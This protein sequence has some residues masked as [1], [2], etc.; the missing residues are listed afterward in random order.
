VCSYQRAASRD[1][2][3]FCAFLRSLAA[4]MPEASSLFFIGVLALK[5]P[6]CAW[7]REA[8]R[9]FESL[10]AAASI[11]RLNNQISLFSSQVVCA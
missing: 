4:S 1:C 11:L 3:S 7:Q 10:H 9:E 8:L 6:G 5:P 2:L